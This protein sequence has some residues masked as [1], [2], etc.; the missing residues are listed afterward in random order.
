MCMKIMTLLWA[1][2][3]DFYFLNIFHS[4]FI[5]LIKMGGNTIRTYVRDD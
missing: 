2:D 3:I 5:I 1:N 4:Y